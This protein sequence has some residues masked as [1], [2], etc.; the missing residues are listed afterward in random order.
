MKSKLIL[1]S[2]FD[3]KPKRDLSRFWQPVFWL[4]CLMISEPL[5]F[6]Q[7]QTGQAGE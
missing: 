4:G 5:L 2:G 1:K 6:A 3:Q 7:T